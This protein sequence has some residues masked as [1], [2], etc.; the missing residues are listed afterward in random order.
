MPWPLQRDPLLCS[1]SGGF[2]PWDEKCGLKSLQS[3]DTPLAL[4]H[5]A[6][7]HRLPRPARQPPCLPPAPLPGTEPPQP[8]AAGTDVRAC[9]LPCLHPGARLH[10]ATELAVRARRGQRGHLP[11][12][13]QGGTHVHTELA[14]WD[15]HLTGTH[16]GTRAQTSRMPESCGSP[17]FRDTHRS[18]ETLWQALTWICSPHSEHWS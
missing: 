12:Q 9:P 7:T 17:G 8:P 13:G 14:R 1:R 5:L 10:G 3:G 4:T 15:S 11:M 16:T 2:C 18:Q 6:S